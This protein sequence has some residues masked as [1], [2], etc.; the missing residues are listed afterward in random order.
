MVTESSSEKLRYWVMT[1][2]HW[3]VGSQMILSVWILLMLLVS[4]VVGSNK[5]VSDRLDDLEYV[6]YAP[7]DTGTMYEKVESASKTLEIVADW[8]DKQYR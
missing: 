5:G 4:M 6:V 2:I 8:L 1:N 3:I 7:D